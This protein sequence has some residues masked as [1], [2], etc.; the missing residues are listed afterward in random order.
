M[1]VT[2]RDPRA[3]RSP[4]CEYGGR[5]SGPGKLSCYGDPGE[6]CRVDGCGT[7]LRATNPYDVCSRCLGRGIKGRKRPPRKGGESDSARGSATCEAAPVLRRVSTKEVEMAAEAR[8]KNGEAKEAVIAYM[9]DGVWRGSP[10]VAAG[11]GISYANAKYHLQR[12]A[13]S[14]H[15]E[16]DGK[17]GKGYRLRQDAAAKAREEAANEDTNARLRATAEQAPA[18]RKTED[19]AGGPA[20]YV[21]SSIRLQQLIL[22]RLEDTPEN[23]HD[24]DILAR[25]WGVGEA[26]IENAVDAIRQRG[27][28]RG[29]LVS[30]LLPRQVPAAEACV[31]A[32]AI[33]VVLL[34][35]GLVVLVVFLAVRGLLITT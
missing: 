16:S 22:K 17:G 15:L 18:E 14:G 31:R 28:H 27:E 33:A 20:P 8:R 24:A 12:L 13:E 21:P 9:A 7:I 29:H 26:D 25:E 30:R 11:C 10:Q 5:A 1:T 35:V 32:Y 4:G 23:Y 3:P 34:S 19:S 2:C 6:P